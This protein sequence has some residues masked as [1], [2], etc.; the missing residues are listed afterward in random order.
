VGYA[1]TSGSAL[2]VPPAGV[3][4]LRQL[5]EARLGLRFT[6]E[7]VPLLAE[8]LLVRLEARKLDAERYLDLLRSPLEF[9]EWRELAQRLTVTETSFFRHPE[10]FRAFSRTALHACLGRHGGRNLNILSA[11]CASGEEPYSL[12]MLIDAA[13]LEPACQI[14]IMGIDINRAA[15][16]KAAAGYYE[17]ATLGE[18]PPEALQRWFHPQNEGY[19]LDARIRA[20]VHFEER[21]LAGDD[22]ALWHVRGYDAVFCR[23]VLSYFSPAL[24]QTIMRRIARALRPG[25]YLFLG[26][27]ENLQGLSA[28]FDLCQSEGS[29]YYR[30]HDKLETASAAPPGGRNRLPAAEFQPRI[31]AETPFRI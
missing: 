15:L 1:G 8:S 18:T 2:S 3:E 31:K 20:M 7:R 11:G 4:A 25:G 10:Q 26:Q 27:T 5:I 6:E 28:D 24:A 16:D 21:N 22:A 9:K 29:F 23:N 12:A 14:S 19:M 30:R 13:N 17:T